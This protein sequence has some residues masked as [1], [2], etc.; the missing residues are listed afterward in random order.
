MPEFSHY[1]T[2]TNDLKPAGRK[3][4]IQY[5]DMDFIFATDSGVFSRDK[6]DG[7]SRILLD[8]LCGLDVSGKLLDLG[9]GWGAIGIILLKAFSGIYVAFADINPRAVELTRRNLQLNGLDRHG[10]DVYVSDGVAD[11]SGSF[12]WIITNP[13]IR[14]GKNAV[15]GLIRGAAAR[16]NPGGRLA[17]VIRRQQGAESMLRFLQNIFSSVSV[18]AKEKGYWV[19]LCKEQQ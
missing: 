14:A 6:L 5:A 10:A 18:I 7:G 4:C 1:F 11:V 13:P 3:V 15:H 2:N 8:A 12:D 9:C 17:L 16:L 19:I